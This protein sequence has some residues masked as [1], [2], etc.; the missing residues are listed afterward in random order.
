MPQSAA[1]VDTA[2]HELEGYLKGIAFDGIITPEETLGIRRWKETHAAYAAHHPFNEIIP[3]LDIALADG[4]ITSGERRDL[5]WLC[6]HF[7]TANLYYNAIHSDLQRLHGLFRG[8]L[9]DSKITTEEIRSLA[10]WLEE[11]CHLASSWPYDEIRSIVANVL[12]DG[13]V[14]RREQQLLKAFFAGFVDTGELPAVDPFEIR[15]LKQ[16]FT[17][18]AVLAHQP[19]VQVAGHAFCFTGQPSRAETARCRKAVLDH[20]GIWQEE[21]ET[22]THFLVVGETANPAWAFACYGRK[23]ELALELRK[24]GRRLQIIRESVFW[25]AVSDGMV[26]PR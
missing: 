11:S 3:V 14:D 24:A 2:I 13:A 10:A 8:I 23:V 19:E 4:R 1:Q 25:K 12:E 22:T 7:T 16:Q 18:P 17:I 5:L 20:G 9:A 26:Q 6:S 15:L 21:P